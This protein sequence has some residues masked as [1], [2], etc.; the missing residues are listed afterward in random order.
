[1]CFS[2]NDPSNM[3][4]WRV[5][6]PCMQFFY[7]FHNLLLFKRRLCIA[8][9]NGVEYIVVKPTLEFLSRTLAMSCLISMS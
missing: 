1:M 5:T 2:K 4:Y 7:L 3:T 8:M 6:D 9:S